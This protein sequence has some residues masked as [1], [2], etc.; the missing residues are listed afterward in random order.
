MVIAGT[1]NNGTTLEGGERR[2]SPSRSDRSR[3][4]TKIMTTDD[5]FSNPRTNSDPNSDRDPE[6]PTIPATIVADS[7]GTGL[8]TIYDE[9]RLTAWI[10]STS[11][12]A[13]ERVA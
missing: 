11:A 1:R 4:P 8:V 6:L 2:C 10:S 3:R 13:L 12:V 7:D 9:R 5:P